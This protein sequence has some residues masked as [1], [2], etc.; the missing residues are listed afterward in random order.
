MNIT[1]ISV[2]KR[3]LF[4]LPKTDVL[5]GVCVM[6]NFIL[7]SLL[8]DD[9]APATNVLRLITLRISVRR[10]SMLI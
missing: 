8:V 6:M 9:L 1:R 5:I 4:Y 2:E 10:C 7:T 3:R